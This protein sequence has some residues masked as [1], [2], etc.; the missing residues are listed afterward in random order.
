MG[1]QAGGVDVEVGLRKF[2]EPAQQEPNTDCSFEQEAKK[3]V[4]DW[5]LNH[6]QAQGNASVAVGL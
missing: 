6:D 2:D 3:I 4:I 5:M 1:G